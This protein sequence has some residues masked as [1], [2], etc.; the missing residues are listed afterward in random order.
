VQ[1]FTRRQ[2]NQPLNVVANVVD[3]ESRRSVEAGETFDAALL[4]STSGWISS[5]SDL[6]RLF[7]ALSAA[8]TSTA[9]APLLAPPSVRAMLER[10]APATAA[11]ERSRAW[12]GLGLVVEDDGRTFWHSGTLDGSTSVVVRDG[13][14]GLTWAALVN[15]RLEPNNDLWDF[16]RYAVTRT[17]GAASTSTPPLQQPTSSHLS[18]SAAA[19]ADADPSWLQQHESSVGDHSDAL[20]RQTEVQSGGSEASATRQAVDS[21]SSDGRT[22]VKLM[23]PSYRVSDTVS[24]LGSEGYR[25]TWLDAVNYHGRLFF[26]VIWTRNDE[27]VR[28]S[29][30]TITNSQS[31]FT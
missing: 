12:Y 25:P 13:D 9:A 22:A 4:D 5:S 27:E 7:E 24:T 26:N 30:P 28:S 21:L 14:V 19:A 3:S 29:A 23:I 18:S 8:A 11:D 17:F 1:Y 16:M 10:R 2:H 6:V 20:R 31:N 15:C